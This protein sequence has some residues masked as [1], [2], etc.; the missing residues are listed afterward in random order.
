MATPLPPHVELRPVTSADL[1]FLFQVYASSRDEERELVGW[2]E[3]AWEHFLRQQFDFQHAQYQ[4][5]Y[6]HP[7]FDLIV[8][9]GRP[10]GCT[11][12]ARWATSGW[13]I[14]PCCAT[15]GAWASA[16]GCCS[17]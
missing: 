1:E 6:D 17:A 9:D 3:A 11:S 16:E 4:R 7:A 2:D 12:I 5:N 10:A 15:T 14:S 8:V 13:W